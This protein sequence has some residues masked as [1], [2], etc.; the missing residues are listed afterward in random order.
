MVNFIVSVALE[1][2]E[3]GAVLKQR[4]EMGCWA[5]WLDVGNVTDVGSF[6]ELPGLH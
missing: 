4:Q 3:T 2:T 5:R 6:T 1:A